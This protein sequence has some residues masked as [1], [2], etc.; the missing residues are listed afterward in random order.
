MRDLCETFS[1]HWLYSTDSDMAQSDHINFEGTTQIFKHRNQTKPR[2]LSQNVESQELWLLKGCALIPAAPNA[3]IDN[4]KNVCSQT[5]SLLCQQSTSIWATALSIMEGGL[6]RASPSVW[7]V[8]RVYF[9]L[10]FYSFNEETSKNSIWGF[11]W[12][13]TLKLKVKTHSG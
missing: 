6:H 2:N 8:H 9:T 11:C 1:V 5:L 7:W 12:V 10:Q 4:Q 13:T 3:E